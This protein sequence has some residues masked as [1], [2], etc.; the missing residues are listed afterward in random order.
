[1]NGTATTTKSLRGF[2]CAIVMSVFAMFHSASSSAAAFQ[3]AFDPWTELYGVATFDVSSACLGT[4]G[5]FN[6]YPDGNLIPLIA[7]GCT[8]SLLGAHIS[9]DGAYGTYHDYVAVYPFPFYPY[10]LFWELAVSGGQL[11][12]L[13]TL[14]PIQL[15]EVGG[16]DPYF[17]SSVAGLAR[18]S[19]DCGPT[20]SFTVGGHVEFSACV[21]GVRQSLP[22]EVTS[23]TRVPE[24]A[25]L[26]LVFGAAFA[27]WIVRRRKRPA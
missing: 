11:A 6:L 4:D 3:V 13:S 25:T 21:D 19:D 22:G 24:P 5:M 9:T 18:G 10:V 15:Q 1:M 27:G 7:D 12:G 20:I 17:L 16:A 23:I 26:G 2:A 8:I 14:V